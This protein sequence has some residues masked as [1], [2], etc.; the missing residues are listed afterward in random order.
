LSPLVLAAGDTVIVAWRHSFGFANR[1]NWGIRVS[2]DGGVTWGEILFVLPTHNYELRKYSACSS[3]GVVY[4]IYSRW[5]QGL[6]FEF[7][8]STNWGNTWSQPTEAFWTQET[9]PIDIAARGDTIH[10]IW[11]GR[12][13]YDDEWEI[14]YI[15]STDS[16]ESWSENTMLLTL[17]DEGSDW[18][19]IAINE[20][21]EL[22]VC[23]MDYK[24]SPNLWRGDLFVRYSSNAGESWTEEEQITFTHDALYPNVIWQ[25]DSIHVVWEDW[26]YDQGDIF[27]MLSEN[28]GGNWGEEERIEDDPG[29]SLAPDLAVVNETVHV[30]WRQDSGM[31]GR[32]IYY[33]RRDEVS[34]IPTLSQWGLLIMALLLLAVATVATSKTNRMSLRIERR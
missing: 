8:K 21:G 28:N 16:G 1:V 24:Y 19:S 32:G 6:L 18:P 14:Y 4:L 26:R 29:M 17:D 3:A 12:F 23:W 20:R 25:E 5:S 34:Q 15:R 10:F 7:T 30:V 2:T 31:D 27:Y 13:N 22:V 33:S 11:V 9:G